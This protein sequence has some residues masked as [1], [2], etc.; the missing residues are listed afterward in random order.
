VVRLDEGRGLR[1]VVGS[2]A[3]YAERDAPAIRRVDAPV[4]RSELDFLRRRRSP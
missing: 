4:R 3:G 2:I 1:W